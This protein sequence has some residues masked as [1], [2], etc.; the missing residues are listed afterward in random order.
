MNPFVD[1]LRKSEF[2]EFIAF[3]FSSMGYG[4]SRVPR[5]LARQGAYGHAVCR[6][7]SSRARQSTS[8]FAAHRDGPYNRRGP[9]C[10]WRIYALT[11]EAKEVLDD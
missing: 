5:S 3:P 10:P 11:C 1:L 7:L 2:R 8:G 6:S 9:T 4:C